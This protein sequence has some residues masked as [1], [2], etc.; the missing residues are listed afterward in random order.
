M[1]R[2]ASKSG[3]TPPGIGE[4][5]LRVTLEAI[6]RDGPLTRTEL[7]LRSGLTGPGISNI[8]RRLQ[9]DGLVVS[10]KRAVAGS[11]QPSTEFA[12][13]PDGAFGIG[14]ALHGSSGEAVLLDLGGRVRQRR[15]FSAEGDAS[16]AIRTAVEALSAETS[17]RLLGIGIGI[18]D[19]DRL[20]SRA[21]RAALPE[22][23]L[24][25]ERDCVTALFAERTYGLG[26]VDGGVML[27]VLDDSLRAGFLFRGVPF[28]GVHG[29]AGSIGTM[30]TGAD[31]VPLDDVASLAAL[32]KVMTPAEQGELHADG[33]LTLSPPIRAW[34]RSAAAHLLDAIVATAGFMAPGAILIGGDVPAKLIDELIRQLSVE[35][36]DTVTR[37]F[38]SPWIS[39]I[40]RTSFAGAGIAIGAALLPFFDVLLPAP[41]AALQ[42]QAIA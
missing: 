4:H 14:I 22:A 3:R 9:D 21:L 33:K 15:L 10:R 2:S 7:G 40:R 29:K 31:R 35:R 37:P 11:G 12:I 32:R 16:A 19:P 34:I 6:R 27:I 41:V 23:R 20:D 13:A 42:P 5:N 30:R 28:S 38:I 26:A 36:D 18:D 1:D 39:P 8:L 24:T 17:G 25:I